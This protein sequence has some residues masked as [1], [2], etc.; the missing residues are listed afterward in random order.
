MD[1]NAGHKNRCTADDKSNENLISVDNKTLANFLFPE[2]E[3][4]MERDITKKSDK[5]KQSDEN[6]RI[7]MKNFEKLVE[8]GMAGTLQSENGVEDVLSDLPTVKGDK[9]FTKFKKTVER[10]PEQVLR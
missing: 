10:N 4:E 7:E 1:W 2:F 8:S 5:N 9:T 3:L 6:L